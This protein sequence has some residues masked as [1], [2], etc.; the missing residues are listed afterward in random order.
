MNFKKIGAYTLAIFILVA[1][2]V[3]FFGT[4]DLRTETAKSN[5]NPAKAKQLLQEMGE[6]HGIQYWDQLATYQVT[7]EDE[8]Y[9]LMGWYGKPF[10]DYNTRFELQYIPESY[11]GT[12]TQVS[13]PDKGEKWGIQSWQTY[14]PNEQGAAIFKSHSKGLFWLPTYQ[15]FIEFPLRIQE[16]TALAYAGTNTINGQRCE[17]VIASWST[18]EPQRHTDQYLIWL[19]AESKQIVKLEYT[20]REMYNFLT[21]AAYYTQYKNYDGVLLPSIMPVESNS[22]PNGLLHE[23]RI[24][25][26]QSNPVSVA[27]LRPNADLPVMGDAK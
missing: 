24:L 7:F 12:L 17:G 9:G 20:I 21:G 27:S 25:N 15:Y 16:A 4:A 23:M 1:A 5:P 10:S 18:T 3:Y 26:F 19:D 2:G 13:G 22:V 8:F 11:D 6:A 14:V